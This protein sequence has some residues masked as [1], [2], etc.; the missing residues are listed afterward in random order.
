MAQV[1]ALVDTLKSALKA[2]GI[3]YTQVAAALQ[4]SESSIK[5]KFSRKEFSLAE[6]D[7]ICTLA[8]I[9]ISELV[10]R[11]EENRGRLQSLSDEQEKEIA[12]D[13]ALLLVAV[14]VLNR[15]TFEQLLEFYNFSDT[16]LVQM[17]ARLD[18]LN[19]MLSPAS[20][21]DLQR[22]MERLA[23]EFDLLNAEDAALPLGEKNG[24]TVLLALRDWHYQTFAS[25]RRDRS[26]E[27][28]K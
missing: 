26:D 21:R 24:C 2:A 14:S 5:R 27:A 1:T 15:W 9:E 7:S 28:R 16:E 11:M 12:A 20:N 19:G 17:L 10:R 13:T 6:L 22:K 8:G 18:R 3:K 23:R 25:L 4:L